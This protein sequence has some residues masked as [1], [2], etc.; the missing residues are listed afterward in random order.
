[1]QLLG[2]V[3]MLVNGALAVFALCGQPAR[4]ELLTAEAKL[5]SSGVQHRFL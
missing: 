5:C 1:M 4:G 2:S 3:R